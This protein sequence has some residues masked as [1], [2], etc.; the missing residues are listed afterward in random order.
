MNTSRKG[1]LNH[2]W[3]SYV[4]KLDYTLAV[5]KEMFVLICEGYV[6]IGNR[7]FVFRKRYLKVIRF[8]G[9]YIYRCIFADLVLAKKILGFY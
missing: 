8:F 1:K 2:N 5:V 9:N 4:I 6:D 3:H 7:T